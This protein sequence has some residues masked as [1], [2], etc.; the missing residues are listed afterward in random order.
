MQPRAVDLPPIVNLPLQ[1]N[2]RGHHRTTGQGCV[3]N[4]GLSS[5][6]D[7]SSASQHGAPT[8]TGPARPRHLLDAAVQCLLTDS[9]CHHAGPSLT[10]PAWLTT[11]NSLGLGAEPAQQS[12]GPMPVAQC[13][14]SLQETP[15]EEI[16]PT[17]NSQTRCG[18]AADRTILNQALG[19]RGTHILCLDSL[20]WGPGY[21][22]T[23]AALQH[24]LVTRPGPVS[25]SAARERPPWQQH[26]ERY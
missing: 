1:G 25:E 15:G 21:L 12:T 23:L 24:G 3:I 18:P 22:T 19:E 20:F 14:S 2:A 9:P 7:P 11:G 26:I 16:K 5:L 4:S 6:T 10:S 8:G 17:G 13:S